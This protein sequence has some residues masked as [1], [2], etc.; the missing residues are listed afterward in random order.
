MFCVIRKLTTW[1]WQTRLFDSSWNVKRNE[2]RVMFYHITCLCIRLR[3]LELKTIWFE[4]HMSV[5]KIEFSY[6]HVYVFCTSLLCVFILSSG[7][8]ITF[9]LKRCNFLIRC[10]FQMHDHS[11]WSV[12]LRASITITGQVGFFV[13]VW[14]TMLCTFKTLFKHPFDSGSCSFENRAI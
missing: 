10:P 7:V 2:I 12:Q 8:S 14:S 5:P 9:H 6:F 4:C 3:R 1:N 13:K 11:K